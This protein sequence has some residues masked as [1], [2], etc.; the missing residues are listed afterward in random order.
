MTLDLKTLENLAGLSPEDKQA[1]IDEANEKYTQ[2]QSATTKGVANMNKAIDFNISVDGDVTKIQEF[3]D[4]DPEA[5]KLWLEKFHPGKTLEQV[6]SNTVPFDQ[7]VNEIVEKKEVDNIIDS[8]ISQLPTEDLKE[9]FKA[10][11]TDFSGGKQP[12]MRNVDDLITATM[13]VINPPTDVNVA[14]RARM[15]AI[16]TAGNKSGG[17]ASAQSQK[18]DWEK[19]IKEQSNEFLKNAGIL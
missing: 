17:G 4:T 2:L 19:S 18:D 7:R 11:L 1:V 16:G 12:T 6:M 10:K 9:K 13:A 14:A 15:A 8:Y 3:F 5:S